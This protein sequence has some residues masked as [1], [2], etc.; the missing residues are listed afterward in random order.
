[1]RIN[2]AD[3]R[4]IIEDEDIEELLAVGAPADEYEP[5]VIRIYGRLAGLSE[6]EWAEDR[7]V[8]IVSEVWDE[9]FGPFDD[10]RRRHREVAY[11]RIAQRILEAYKE[12]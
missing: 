9:E 12:R 7:L 10:E 11:R 2:D 5:E 3:L 4:R 1:M 8:A 6:S